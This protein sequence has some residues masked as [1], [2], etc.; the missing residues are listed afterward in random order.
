MKNYSPTESN[1]LNTE[2]QNQKK[3]INISPNIALPIK[4]IPEQKIN[5]N[6]NSNNWIEKNKDYIKINATLNRFEIYKF[7]SSKPKK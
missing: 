2:T 1:K 3:Y 7:N 4:K 5:Q 6:I